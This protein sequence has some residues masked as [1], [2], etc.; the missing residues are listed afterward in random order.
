MSIRAFIFDLDGVI[1]DTAEYH[2]L[3]WKQLADE[4]DLPFTK[5]DND[6]LRGVSR[7]ES[8]KRLLKGR[9]IP[10][11][12]TQEWMERKNRYFLMHLSCLKEDDYLPGVKSFLEE[13]QALQI[14]LGIGSASKNARL[15]LERLSL[16]HYFEVI[17]DGYSVVNL[18]PAP[19]LFVWVADKL[20]VSE[21]ETI[22]FEDA[23]AGIDAARQAGC[24]TVSIGHDNIEHADLHLPNGFAGVSVADILN[25][26]GGE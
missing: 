2:Y 10:E 6:A 23:Q 18:K 20:Q 13:A 3:S 14:R 21:S 24:R 17:G 25:Y 7:R 19:D 4:E 15:V 9:T 16:T 22:V 11:E 12:Q 5:A 26:F 1:T 8:L